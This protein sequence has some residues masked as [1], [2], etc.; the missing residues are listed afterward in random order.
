MSQPARW[1]WIRHA[2]TDAAGFCGWTDAP[3]RLDAHGAT[4]D[5]L[6]AALAE[7]AADARLLSS[8]LSRAAQTAAALFPG[9]SIAPRAAFREQNFGDWEGMSY[10]ALGAEHPFWTAPADAAPPNG[11]RFRDVVDRVR[12]ALAAPSPQARTTVAV[13]HAGAIRAALAVALDL[14]PA[15][16]LRFEIAPLSVTELTCWDGASWSIAGVNR[17]AP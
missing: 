1:I 12:A 2:P 14:P 9:R 15:Q 4:I 3:A 10:D 7:S 13:A 8:D 5:R 16:A 17:R 6:R 11:E